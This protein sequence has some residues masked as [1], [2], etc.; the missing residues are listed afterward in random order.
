MERL[1]GSDQHPLQHLVAAAVVGVLMAGCAW[2][3]PPRDP[4]V[5][6]PARPSRTVAELLDEPVR[7][8][9]KDADFEAITSPQIVPVGG[10]LTLRCHVPPS[11][12]AEHVRLALVLPGLSAPLSNKIGPVY[13]QLDVVGVPCGAVNDLAQAFALPPVQAR[14]MTVDV[15]HP[16]TP[17]PVRLIGTPLKFSETPATVRA[18]PPTLGQHTEEV[19]SDLLRLT[20]DEI[21]DLR[22]KGAI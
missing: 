18:A 6:V 17:A 5:P 12:E 3:Y 20:R 13:S 4:N 11:W 10:A 2:T 16:A 21:D 8:V 14:G 19:L 1:G 9:S 22:N 7:A 15:V